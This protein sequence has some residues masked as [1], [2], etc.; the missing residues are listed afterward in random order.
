MSDPY[1][2][3]ALFAASALSA[4]L[5]YAGQRSANSANANLNAG[6]MAY[7]WGV[8]QWQAAFDREMLGRQQEYNTWQSDLGREFANQQAGYAREFASREAAI[9]RGFDEY[10]SNTS[11]QRARRDMIAAGLNPILAYQQGGASTPSAPLPSVGIPSAP[12]ATSGLPSARGLGAPSMQRMENALGPAVGSAMQAAQAVMGVQQTAAQIDQTKAQTALAAAQEQ[13][14]RTQAGLNSAATI[15]E[16]ERAGLVSAQR[17]TELV[18]PA[19]RNAQ[20]AA[21]NAQAVLAGEQS[22][23]EYERQGLTREQARQAGAQANFTRTQEEMQRTYGPP[24]RVSSTIGGVAQSAQ[25]AWD[26]VRNLFR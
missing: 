18:N 23:T 9:A 4:G 20:T 22:R 1:T 10:M 17:A 13:Q 7:N 5:N 2:A 3:A 21:N 25:S 15:T 11:Y 26:Y 24:G 8:T 12:N 16:A 6:T 14:A 19:L